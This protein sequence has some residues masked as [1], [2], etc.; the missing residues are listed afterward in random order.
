MGIKKREKDRSISF[1]YKDEA[2]CLEGI[3]KWKWKLRK[4]F[5]EFQ[6]VSVRVEIPHLG[7]WELPCIYKYNKNK[8]KT[9][10]FQKRESEEKREKVREREEESE[11]IIGRERK[12]N[13]EKIKR[14][15]WEEKDNKK[16]REKKVREKQWESYIKRKN[17]KH[18]WK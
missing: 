2:K 12:R 15:K 1:W 18:L 11:K 3:K 8:Q 6:E 13:R 4:K 7:T 14:R 16:A 9:L 5:K 10:R 17:E